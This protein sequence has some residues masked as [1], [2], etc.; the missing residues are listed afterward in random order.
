MAD[1]MV[2]RFV[3]HPLTREKEN[4]ATEYQFV[5]NLCA[6]WDN[7]TRALFLSFTR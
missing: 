1:S 3:L 2:E 7:I 6:T 5:G 4:E